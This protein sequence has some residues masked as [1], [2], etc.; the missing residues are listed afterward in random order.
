MLLEKLLG[1][2]KGAQVVGKADTEISG[3]ASDSREVE[4][5]TL[6]VALSGQT[7]DGHEFVLD[8]MSRGA[9][10]VVVNRPVKQVGSVAVVLVSDTREVLGPLSAAFYDYPSSR[11]RMVGVTGTNGKTTTTYLIRQILKAEGRR[12]GLLGTISYDLDQERL[13][14]PYTT[15]DAPLLQKLLGQMIEQEIQDVVMEVSSHALE[16]DRVKDCEFDCAVFTNL[17]QDH[18]DFHGSM[19]NYFSTKEKLFRGLSS[20]ELKFG[21][22]RAIIN[23]EDPWGRKLLDRSYS[24]RWSY[25]FS[26][27]ADI[28]GDAVQADREGIQMEV[29]TPLGVFPVQS[30]LLGN[31]NASNILAAIGVGLHYGVSIPVI[32]EGISSMLGVP[33]RF[34]RVEAGQSYVVIVDYAHTESALK[35]LLEAVRSMTL[36]RV[37][38]VFGCGG[39]RDTGKRIPM[40]RVAG[41]LGD[42]III[43]SDNPRSEDPISIIQE[44][45]RGVQEGVLSGGHTKD[46]ALVPDRQQAI[47]RAIR[48]A[49]AGD[50]VVIA[51]KGHED[52]Q[53]IGGKKIP[54]DDRTIALSA[55]PK[56]KKI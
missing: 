43:T 22:K 25:G 12:V 56:R 34:E 16:L 1:T 14:A 32:Q 41:R 28:W 53:L 48:D 20:N 35:L 54:F 2:I 27:R 24:S 46:Y 9:A 5:G 39:D 33:G 42:S 52:Y 55:I 49:G 31:Y 38:V 47:E 19:E 4:K 3:I 44:I 13:S 30:P 51:G 29:H 37:L 7:R 21:L 23:H 6:F 40:G 50:T 26:S 10:G 17:S 45:E 8:A 18:L 36:G 15:P 11:L